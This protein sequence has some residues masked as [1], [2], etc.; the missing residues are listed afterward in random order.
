M[1]LPGRF[2][3]S[4]LGFCTFTVGLIASLDR[5]SLLVNLR[6]RGKG[7]VGLLAEGNERSQKLNQGDFRSPSSSH[8][9][10]VT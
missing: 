6:I 7:W 2:I 9:Q 8:L 4:A 5:Q 10:A 3:K 1:I